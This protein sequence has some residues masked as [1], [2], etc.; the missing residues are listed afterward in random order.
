MEEG[1]E[2]ALVF[3]RTPQNMRNFKSFHEITPDMPS[4]NNRSRLFLEL[5]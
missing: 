1:L 5:K 2:R 4:L 3:L